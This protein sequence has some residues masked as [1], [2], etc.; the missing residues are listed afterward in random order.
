MFGKFYTQLYIDELAQTLSTSS[1][2][3]SYT[4]KKLNITRKKTTLYEERNEKNRSQFKQEL[5]AI[6]PAR[7]VYTYLGI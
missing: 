1:S 7:M 2:T 3:I 6:N 4:L 5:K